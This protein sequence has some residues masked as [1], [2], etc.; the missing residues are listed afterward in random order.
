MS[1]LIRKPG[2]NDWHEPKVT[3]YTDERAL[4]ALLRASPSLLPR[5]HDGMAVAAEFQVPG[6][7]PAD[8]IAVDPTGNIVVVECKLHA[9]PEIRRHVV[10]Q[11]FAYAAGL[12][13]L[14][15][16]EF[17]REFTARTGKPVAEQLASVAGQEWDEET[18]RAS[19]SASLRDGRFRLV[20][21][22]DEITPELKRIILFLNERTASQLE[23]VALELGYV[24][25]EGVEILLPAV[26]GEESAQ[27]KTHGAGWDRTEEA[28]FAELRRRC[29]PEGVSAFR[30]LF[31]FA[32]TRGHSFYWGEGGY[33]SVTAWFEIEGQPVATWSCYVYPRGPSLEITFQWLAARVSVGKLARFADRLRGIP[34]VADRFQGLEEA[35]FRR[36]P[37]LPLDEFLTEPSAIDTIEG[38][39]TE[40]IETP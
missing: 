9:N 13:E 34:G 29:T 18:F 31:D 28:L 24:A 32:Q 10:G 17:D 8:L 26:Y 14:S 22:V 5:G 39:L 2:S 30:R 6:T 33:P 1:L 16:E 23:V 25:D 38:G 36:R 20:I 40:L 15:Y 7:G 3:A 19:L 37:S 4:Q 12:W 35:Q 21:A 27:S 11:V